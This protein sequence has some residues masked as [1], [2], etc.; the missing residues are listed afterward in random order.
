M[1]SPVFY[2][3]FFLFLKQI[4]TLKKGTSGQQFSHQIG[5]HFGGQIV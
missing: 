2:F 1:S 4:F 3:Q 5:G